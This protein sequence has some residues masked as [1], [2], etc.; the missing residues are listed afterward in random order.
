MKVKFSINMLLVLLFSWSC[1]GN[2][3]AGGNAET[4]FFPLKEFMEVQ[5]EKITGMTLFKEVKVN[6]E[7]ESNTFVPEYEGW[8]KE[9]EFF[10]Q[11][12][13]NRPALAQAYETQR[14]ER[15]LIHE[16]K[17]GEKGKIKKIIVEYLK[18]EVKQ[19]S[20]QSKTENPFYTSQTRGVVGI[21]GV[22]KLIDNFAIETVQEVIFSKPNKI[23]ISAHLRN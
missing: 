20:F 15:F 9:L 7:K 2:N 21:H 3:G 16:L 17:E 10:I 5:A 4:D 18:G 23:V 12:D 6:G 13:I 1:T 11:A 19:I 14:S 8:L 22:T